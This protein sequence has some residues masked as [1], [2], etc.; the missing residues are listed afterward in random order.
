M[1]RAEK[2]DDILPDFFS[3]FQTFYSFFPF[4]FL[5]GYEYIRV[6]LKALSPLCNLPHDPAIQLMAYIWKKWKH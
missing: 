5:L 3:H 4:K 6:Q 2:C 1:L